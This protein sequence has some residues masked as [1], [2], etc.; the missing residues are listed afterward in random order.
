[1]YITRHRVPGTPPATLVAPVGDAGVPPEITLIEYDTDSLE[2][3]RPT[4]IEEVFSCKTNSKVSW[5]NIDGLGD[6]EVFRKLGAHFEF[7]P[8]ALEDVLSL[9]Q[10]PKME[11]HEG[12]IFLVLQMLYI[13]TEMAVCAEQ[14]AMFVGKNYVITIQE[15][16][17]QDVFEPLRQ[18]LRQ[19]RG[20][21]R[22]MG[23]DYL[24]YALIDCIVDQYFPVLESLGESIEDIEDELTEHPSAGIGTDVVS[25]LYDIRR[26]TLQMRR[27]AWPTREVI[28]S[29]M[30]DETG[31]LTPKT[32]VFLRDCYD[33][34]VQIIDI[35]ETY[36][37]ILGGLMEIYLS[38]LTTRT[39]DIIRVLTV[40]SSIFIP[41]TFIAGVY[42]MNFDV[43]AGPLSMPEL[44]QPYGYVATLAFMLCTAL[45]MLTYFRHKRW[46]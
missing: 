19:G 40:I 15:E 24:M 3:K 14:V 45:G 8:L 31:L 43:K 30:R 23:A 28:N 36:R 17:G 18:R 42:G 35:L 25:R 21:A 37:E 6:V 20:F 2:E 33:H 44:N 9:G 41:L 10:R 46:I 29:L 5:I 22:P 13:N 12:H 4:S 7:H 1:M 38:T 39:N 27:S 16:H 32:R 11:T 26:T 34:A